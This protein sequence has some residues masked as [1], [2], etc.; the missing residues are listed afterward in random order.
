[1]SYQLTRGGEQAVIGVLVLAL[2][3]VIVFA[4]VDRLK[5]NREIAA[6]VKTNSGKAPEI[7]GRYMNAEV[8]GKSD[9][10]VI[11]FT[12]KEG[13]KCLYYGQSLSC[14]WNKRITK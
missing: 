8:L 7:V 12:T 5:T 6:C 4:L 3:G 2:C 14:D 1:M 13:V 10:Q 9:L 11:E